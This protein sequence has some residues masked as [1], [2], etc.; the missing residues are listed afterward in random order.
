MLL[1][2]TLLSQRLL[3]EKEYIRLN[4]ITVVMGCM[5]EYREYIRAIV[6]HK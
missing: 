6:L 4:N 3:K 5:V 2:G 1:C